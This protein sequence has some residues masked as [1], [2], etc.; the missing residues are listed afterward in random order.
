ME[1]RNGDS[2]IDCFFPC[3]M[4]HADK[5]KF[6]VLFVDRLQ[7]IILASSSYEI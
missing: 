7:S 1:P 3:V 2:Q 4:N 5:R 6:R